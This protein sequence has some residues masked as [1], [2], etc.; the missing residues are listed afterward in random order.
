MTRRRGRR[1][2]TLR[3]M[4]RTE[5]GK[6][7]FVPKLLVEPVERSARLMVLSRPPFGA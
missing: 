1:R 4:E 5:P 2:Y 7:P 3:S 6:G